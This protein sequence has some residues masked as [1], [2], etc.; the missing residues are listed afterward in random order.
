MLDVS[1]VN[2]LRKRNMDDNA[3][4]RSEKWRQKSEL[5]LAKLLVQ[6]KLK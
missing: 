5:T 4:R 2:V 1:I 6:L 3:K